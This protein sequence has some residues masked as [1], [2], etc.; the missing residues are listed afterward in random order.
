M[1]D[2]TGTPR[3][4]W[5]SGKRAPY[6]GD[7]R[8]V[9][10]LAIN[11]LIMSH[12]TLFSPTRLC[13]LRPKT[14]FKFLIFTSGCAQN[15]VSTQLILVGFHGPHSVSRFSLSLS[16]PSFVYSLVVIL[17]HIKVDSKSMLRS[18]DGWCF[19]LVEWFTALLI[20]APTGTGN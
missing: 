19:L 7:G 1:R 17:N 8:E 13:S 15:S 20:E 3:S 14:N 16:L 18:L 2:C 4:L 12:S 6:S 5:E 9:M 10:P 11:S